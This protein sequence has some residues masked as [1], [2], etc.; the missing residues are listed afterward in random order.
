M[1]THAGMYTFHTL[2]G[3]HMNIHAST[4]TL[5]LARASN[6]QEKIKQKNTKSKK[7][8]TEERTSDQTK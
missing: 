1:H 6:V 7:E 4:F 3:R 5:Q 8:R 2:T